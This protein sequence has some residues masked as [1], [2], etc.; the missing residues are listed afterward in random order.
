MPE[1]SSKHL[2]V[3]CLWGTYNNKYDLFL[4]F[5]FLTFFYFKYILIFLFLLV[6]H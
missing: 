2:I 5:H 1:L 6:L 3:L 4:N